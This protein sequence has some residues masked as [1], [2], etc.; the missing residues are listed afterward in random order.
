MISVSEKY[1]YVTGVDTHAREHVFTIVESATARVV[2]TASF[3]TSTAGLARA[4]SW[5]IRHS[6]SVP[7]VVIEGIGSYGAHLAVRMTHA[8]LDVVEPGPIP[9]VVKRG[10]GKTDDL[11]S[12]RIACSVLATTVDKLRRP[13]FDEGIRDSLR[14]LV[15]ARDAMNQER[16]RAMNQTTAIVRTT[17][18]GIDARA[19]LTRPQYYDISTWRTRNEPLHLATARIEASRLATRV[20]TLEKD[21][22]DNATHLTQIIKASPYSVLLDLPGVGPITAADVIIAWGSKGRIRSEAAFASLA[23]TSPLPASSGNTNRY[24][25]N[26]GGDRHLN[27]AITTI[28]RSRMAHDP[29]TRAY[30]ADHLAHGHTKREITRILK[31]YITRQLFKT[32]NN[33][34]DA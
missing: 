32:L 20:L 17:S 14:V 24:R 19:A 9:A 15:T 23:G 3:P 21:L 28:T 10:R 31:R 16:T 13:R 1:A 22:A 8:G 33:I 30:V 27:R 2:D 25:L 11:D 26:R 5:T 18:L 29:N 6:P 34:P 4:V 7:L 12:V